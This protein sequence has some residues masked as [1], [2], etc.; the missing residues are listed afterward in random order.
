[1]VN[2]KTRRKDNE[3]NGILTNSN[4]YLITVN[5]NGVYI[6]NNENLK[7]ARYATKSPQ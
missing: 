6:L 4:E 5:L 7:F 1:M 3:R 2:A